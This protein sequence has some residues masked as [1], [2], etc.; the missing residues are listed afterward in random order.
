[1]RRTALLAACA[2]A[3]SLA[4]G[5]APGFAAGPGAAP[6]I[7]GL[8]YADARAR[9][10]RAGWRPAENPIDPTNPD[11]AS[12][13][14]PYFVAR[15]YRELV[16]CAGTGRAPCRFAFRRSGRILTVV[17]V[18]EGRDARVSAARVESGARD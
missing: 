18:G 13:N 5:A 8:P 9:L 16:A 4:A 17:T 3:A 6:R 1:M 12:G 10:I 11:L 2:L 7:V 15:G 14:G